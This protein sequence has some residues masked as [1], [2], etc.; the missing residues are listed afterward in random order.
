MQ[1]VR[2]SLSRLVFKA[3]IGHAATAKL[4]GRDR[5]L[6]ALKAIRNGLRSKTS[7]CPAFRHGIS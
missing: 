2:A 1:S 7:P 6:F 3:A 5:L 4:Q